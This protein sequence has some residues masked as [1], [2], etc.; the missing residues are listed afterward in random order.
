MNVLGLGQTGSSDQ[1][2]V[3]DGR[4]AKECLFVLSARCERRQ[5]RWPRVHVVVEGDSSVKIVTEQRS[6]ALVMCFIEN[7]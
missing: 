4:S 2:V 3:T 6:D 7:C 1:E 5:P